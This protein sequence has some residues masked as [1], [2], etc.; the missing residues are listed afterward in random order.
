MKEGILLK[1]YYAQTHNSQANYVASVGGD[2]F[3]LNHDEP[4]EIPSNVSTLI[5]LLD[6]QNI[7]W[8]GYFEGIPGPGYMG[9]GSTAADRSGWDYVRKH[10]YVSIKQRCLIFW[11]AGY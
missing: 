11:T 6:T 4:V 7:G 3:G 2:Y 8:K 10:K 5:D 1:Q 9:R